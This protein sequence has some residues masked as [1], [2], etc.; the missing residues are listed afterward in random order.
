MFLFIRWII[1]HIKL[2]LLFNYVLLTSVV[3]EMVKKMIK[4]DDFHVNKRK[5][6]RRC[7]WRNATG[8]QNNIN[9]IIYLF[10]HLNKIQN[11]KSNAAFVSR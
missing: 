6:K 5:R 3:Y 10:T 7:K 4:L 1:I 11:A 2:H 9:N 8:A